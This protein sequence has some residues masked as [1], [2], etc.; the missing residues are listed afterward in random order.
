MVFA[1]CPIQITYDEKNPT[2]LPGLAKTKPATD[3]G[4]KQH[5]LRQ[6]LVV[7]QETLKIN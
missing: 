3:A 4:G 5:P 1:V 7:I 6:K 2:H